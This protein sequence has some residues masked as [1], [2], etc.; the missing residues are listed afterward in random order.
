MGLIVRQLYS[1]DVTVTRSPFD[2]MTRDE[3]FLQQR[4]LHSGNDIL[5]LVPDTDH[6]NEDAVMVHTG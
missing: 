3:V 1:H 2:G 4:P 6:K 5:L